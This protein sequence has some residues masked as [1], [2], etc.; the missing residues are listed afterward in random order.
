[1]WYL[2]SGWG[3]WRSC[4]IANIRDNNRP[5][6]NEK[7]ESSFCIHRMLFLNQSGRRWSPGSFFACLVDIRNTLWHWNHMSMPE[8]HEWRI[9]SAHE[10]H[11]VHRDLLHSEQAL[12]SD[13]MMIVE[14]SIV[15]PFWLIWSNMKQLR[16][17]SDEISLWARQR[18]RKPSRRELKPALTWVN[19]PVGFSWYLPSSSGRARVDFRSKWFR[20][21]EWQRCVP[22]LVVIHA[23]VCYCE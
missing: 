1:M 6:D 8:Q 17:V 9:N 19:D 5:T 14:H 2:W 21:N 7:F 4:A 10:I 13:H 16:F 12:F 23:D 20:R 22:P 3:A 15:F 18:P 11:S